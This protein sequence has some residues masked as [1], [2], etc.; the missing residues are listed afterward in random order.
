MQSAT[1]LHTLHGIK[2][3]AE[4]RKDVTIDGAQGILA[5]PLPL[6]GRVSEGEQSCKYDGNTVSENSSLSQ[7]VTCSKS[8]SLKF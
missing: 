4:S 5:P 7:K 3:T 8:L 1:P 6:W 2:E